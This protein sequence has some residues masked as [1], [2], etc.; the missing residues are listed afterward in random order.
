MIDAP[1]PATIDPIVDQL[2]DALNNHDVTQVVA[3]YQANAAHV[4]SRRTIAG[5]QALT[6]WYS[7]LFNTHLPN[8]AF[9]LFSVQQDGHVIKFKWNANSAA[10]QVLDGDDTMQIRA[11][12]IQYHFTNFK[13]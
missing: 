3:L 11:G 4:N 12:K 1:P 2:R 9:N 8:G 5:S 6:A 7:E 10:R 13:P